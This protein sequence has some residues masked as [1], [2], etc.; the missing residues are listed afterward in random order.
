MSSSGSPSSNTIPTWKLTAHLIRNQWQSFTLYALFTL[1]LFAEQLVPG[2]IA[3]AIFDRLDGDAASSQAVFLWG[4]IV[5][6]LGVEIARL[7][8]GIGHEYYG[9]TFRLL[10]TAVLRS[11]LMASILRRLS[12]QPL[13]VSSGEALNR[14]HYYE[15]MGE[16]TD[17]PTWLP[18]Q[19]SKWI[20]AAIAVIIMARINLMI[21]LVVFLPLIGVIVISRLVWSS[22]LRAYRDGRLAQDA[23]I[24]F[25]GEAFGAVQ[26]VK[27]AGAET[28]VVAHLAALNQM[29]AQTDL[30]QVFYRGLLSALNNSVVSFGIGVMLLL[31]G[32][33]ISEA[34]FSVGDFA[35]FVSYLWFTTQVPS[36]IGTFFGDYQTQSVSLDRLLELVR[37][38]PAEVLVKQRPI[39]WK[40]DLTEDQT[41]SV[42]RLESLE[43]RDLTYHYP[44]AEHTRGLTGITFQ[45]RGGD[46]VVI[47]GRMGSG[48]SSLV[49]IFSGLLNPDSGQIFWNGHI[50]TDPAS[51]F[52]PPR[53]A[54]TAQTPR[55]FSESL[56]DNILLGLSEKQV[57]LPGALYASVL[58]DDLTVLEQGL[59][60]LVGPRGV[61]LSGGQVQRVAAARMFVRPAE[62][63]IFDD[64]SSAL[65][66]DTERKFW[67]RVDE[68]RA[69]N[70]GGL[71]CLVVSHRQPVL[72]RADWILVLKDGQIES[73][74]K[75]DDLLKTSTEMQRLW[76]GEIEG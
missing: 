62:L 20:A 68:R 5:L 33:S 50:I 25:L 4:L 73:Q 12:D 75:L 26:A 23:A 7:L 43:V 28:G 47:T 63:Y 14:F 59:D 34:Q 22:L 60:T 64:I 71:T 66:L 3:K 70:N 67:Q 36:E 6:Y 15:D 37:P 46:F 52:R 2:L 8:V 19:I 30:R 69:A 61:R 56:G 35:L 54:Y 29:R 42:E 44:S 9:M 48:K 10:S 21:T 58:E 41:P 53:A 32:A 55:L 16:I 17:F 57:D 27:V 72:R 45:V 51:F 18:D 39:E 65:D 49:R 76:R 40:Y 38:E 24:G 31:L 1:F 11:N 13:P 74:G